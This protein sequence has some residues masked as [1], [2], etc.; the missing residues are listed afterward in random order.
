M[1][2]YEEQHKASSTNVTILR[3]LPGGDTTSVAMPETKFD[4]LHPLL[5]ENL[6]HLDVCRPT[7]E[8]RALPSQS[9][10]LC[11][12]DNSADAVL[13]APTGQGKTLAYLIVVVNRLLV[14]DLLWNEIIQSNPG[15][16]NQ[17]LSHPGALVLVPN[18][19]LAL[20]VAEVAKK[21][22]FGSKLQVLVLIGG[23]ERF[24]PNQLKNMKR[25]QVLVATPGRLL[26]HVNN[27]DISLAN[28]S[29]LVL[30]EVDRLTKKEFSEP[31]IVSVAT[32][33]FFL[34]TLTS[35]T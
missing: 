27:S 26:E 24:R 30:D 16:D 32:L 6:S 5:V 14:K 7:G 25:L 31:I 10:C 15:A 18:R 34:F 17:T 29:S 9:A 13:V 28:V 4:C 21:L 12:L 20:Q 11:L 35:L 1:A 23:G 33:R 19:E 2:Q 8:L 22:L 3:V